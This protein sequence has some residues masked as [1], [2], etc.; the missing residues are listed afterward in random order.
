MWRYGDA[1]D[2][3]PVEPGQVWVVDAPPLDTV[4]TSRFLCADLEHDGKTIND[5]LLGYGSHGMPFI[6]CSYTDLPYNQGLAQGFR[7]KA[8]LKNKADFEALT[9]KVI[10]YAS[11]HVA[12][13][14]F[15]EVGREHA[16]RIAN[17]CYENDAEDVKT[18]GITYH[19]TAPAALIGASWQDDKWGRCIT[20]ESPEGMDDM[21]TPSWAISCHTNE[22]E[23]VLDL[24]MGR[25]LTA[26]SAR[27]LDR[28]VVG[29]ELHPRRL[30]VTLD[31]VSKLDRSR[32]FKEI[33]E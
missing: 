23:Y 32:P 30:A 12:G 5:F 28:H 9:E 6:R 31:K 7:T 13:C 16:D 8:G 19:K 1:G 20:E 25:G 14:S 33:A 18:W 29:V 22:G 10:D 24:C 4:H 2:K 3:Y 21:H 27:K 26:T 11:L 17:L 15:F